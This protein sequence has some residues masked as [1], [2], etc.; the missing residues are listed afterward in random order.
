MRLTFCGMKNGVL[1]LIFALDE[2]SMERPTIG[3]GRI[4]IQGSRV[5]GG[6]SRFYNRTL[7]GRWN[8]EETKKDG[9]HVRRTWDHL[10][11]EFLMS[12][13]LHSMMA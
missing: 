5:P 7:F 10:A 3:E 9:G 12:Y 6:H 11:S 4:V 8:A 13:D 2:K 1:R